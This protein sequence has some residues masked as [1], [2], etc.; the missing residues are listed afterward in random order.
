MC[1]ADKSIIKPIIKEEI[2]LNKALFG[3]MSKSASCH[4]PLQ[5]K[6]TAIPMIKANT[7]LFFDF[8]FLKVGIILG[9]S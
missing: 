7:T 5:N 9:F 3:K 2:L 8:S 6:I 1:L 4:T